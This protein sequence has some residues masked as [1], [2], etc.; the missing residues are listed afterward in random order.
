MFYGTTYGY[1]GKC[2]ICGWKECVFCCWWNILYMF[3]RPCWFE[4]LFNFSIPLFIFCLA[5][6][7]TEILQLLL[8]NC[9]FLT[10]VLFYLLGILFIYHG[11]FIYDH[12]YNCH[13]FLI[14]WH[15]CHYKMF[16]IWSSIFLFVCFKGLIYLT[17]EWP[18]SS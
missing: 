16:F 8:L 9:L 1:S 13:N 5:V 14:Y 6:L 2:S 4:V 17:L 7:V 15:F 10:L 18:L 12:D 11:V 3:V